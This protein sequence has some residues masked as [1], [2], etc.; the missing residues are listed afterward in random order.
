MNQNQP[1]MDEF[2]SLPHQ[3]H[4]PSFRHT[5]RKI[6]KPFVNSYGVVI[7][8]SYY[9][10]TQSPLN[11]WSEEID[12]EVMAGP[13]WVHPTNDIGWNTNE[14]RQLLEQNTLNEPEN[15]SHPYIDTSYS[16]D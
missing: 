14:N 10:S 4:A 16:T 6:Q 7:G 5:G 2:P 12:P 1:K 15:F 3:I 11:H 9:N 13:E 8:D